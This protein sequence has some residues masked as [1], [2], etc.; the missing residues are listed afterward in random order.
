MARYGHDPAAAAHDDV[1]ALAHDSE[2]G[3]LERAHGVQMVDA[4]NLRERLNDHFDLA[5]V[6]ALQLFV[7][8]REIFSDSVFDV[9]QGL[10]LGRP[11]RPA[12]R[13]PGDG[14]AVPFLG[15]VQGYAVFH[16]DDSTPGREVSRRHVD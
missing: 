15:F 10:V 6:S 12:A 16:R 11:L 2:S 13:Q 9:L 5:N 3:F 8:N 7:D 1:L 14:S 4:G